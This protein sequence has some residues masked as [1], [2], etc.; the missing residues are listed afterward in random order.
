M[1]IRRRPEA[2]VVDE[3]L[4]PAFFGEL[5]TERT[6][7]ATHA[8]FR[9]TKTSLTTPEAAT[10]LAKALKIKAGLVT[11][12]GLKDKH[13]LTTQH[14]TAPLA[15]DAPT[16]DAELTGPGWKAVFLGWSPR[17]V[18]AADIEANAFAIEVT[19]LTREEIK[20]MDRRAW[21]LLAGSSLAIANYYGDQR[22]GSARHGEGFAGARLVR[23]DY[24]G[25]L[26]LLVGVPARKD[27][28]SRRTLTRACASSWGEWK[29][30][31]RETPA[32]AERAS[33]EVLAAGGSIRDA[34]AA[35]PHLVQSLC[36][37]AYQSWLWN[38]IVRAM[39]EKGIA[40]GDTLRTDD[41]FGEMVF[42]A[43]GAVPEPWRTL[44]IPLPSPETKPQGLWGKA[45]TNVMK[46]EGIWF[47]T[48]RL[49]G[50]R[51]PTFADSQRRMFALAADFTM[52]PPARDEEAPPKSPKAWKRLVTFSLPRGAFATTVLRALGQ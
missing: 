1:T 9:L 14:V 23:G 40:P 48:L 17:P 35:L 52:S 28:G 37:E 27:T 34:F 11:R 29:K 43:S 19:A 20:E 5:A 39:I 33:I 46:R 18:E 21:L 38:A 50:L 6:D 7:A 4:G 15:P 12:A 13:A 42:P 10:R 49:P 32:C 24:E 3:R 22:F 25:A 41:D 8:A 2:F 45:A 44:E 47:D 36:V 26:K 51:R 30:I 16:P 31:V